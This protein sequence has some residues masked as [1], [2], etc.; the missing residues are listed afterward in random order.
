MRWKFRPGKQNGRAVTT[1]AMVE[2]N[3][4]LL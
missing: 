3:F 4:R 1:S 2:V